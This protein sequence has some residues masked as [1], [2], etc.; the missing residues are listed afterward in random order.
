MRSCSEYL[1]AVIGGFHGS[2]GRMQCEWTRNSQRRCSALF[3]IFIVSCGKTHSGAGPNLPADNVVNLYIWADYLAPDTLSSFEA[4]TGVKVNVTYFDTLAVPE[5]RLLTMQPR[6]SPL[7]GDDFDTA[8]ASA[9]PTQRC[10][11]SRRSTRSYLDRL[12]QRSG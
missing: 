12:M 6:G 1:L 2:P 9:T 8:N 7:R 10:D 4:R 3:T 5:T 11:C